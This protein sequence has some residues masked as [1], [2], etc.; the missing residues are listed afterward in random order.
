VKLRNIATGTLILSL[1]FLTGCGGEG[2][3]A[4]GDPITVAEQFMD[5]YYHKANIK[6][7]AAL[8]TP[9]TAQKIDPA[10]GS[11]AVDASKEKDAGQ[12]ISY[13][14]KEKSMEGKHSYALY[15]ITITRKDAEPIYKTTALFIDLVGEAW[16]ITLFDEKIHNGPHQE[17]KKG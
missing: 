5:L 13:F 15:L 7:A 17:V 10:P 4:K 9:E 3:V 12:E 2:G 11:P 6:E 1:F 8:A 14:L 16:K